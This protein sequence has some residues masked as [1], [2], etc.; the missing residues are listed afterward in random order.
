MEIYEAALLI[1]AGVFAGFLNTVAGG[2]SLI[3]LPIMIFM[4]LPPA[5]ANGS[6][7][8]AIFVQN[9]FGT[10]GFRSKGI[11]TWPYSGYL[12]LSA[13]VG[14]IIGAQISVEISGQLF[15]RILS[16]VMLGVMLVTVFNPL[17]SKRDGLER[18]SRKY[19]IIGI[20]S[21]FF[22]G[23]YGGFIQAGVGFI[24]IALLSSINHM[25]L[26]R[27]NST[28]VFVA[29]VYTISAIVIF[30]LNGKINWLWGLTLAVGNSTG[31]WIGSRWQVNKGE[32]WIKR[33]LFAAIL[34]MSIKLWMS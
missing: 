18:M 5:V 17:K 6:N 12:G 4:G 8:I 24:I 28:K 13:L 11:S 19:V 20:I 23:V 25:N 9:I 21:F 1:S 16:V 30:A 7:R 10:A 34:A 15:N 29:L 32:K 31:A 14:A 3:T 26:I 33:V 22:V 27:T 2:G